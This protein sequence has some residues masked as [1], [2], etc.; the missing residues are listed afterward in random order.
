MAQRGRGQVRGREWARGVGKTDLDAHTQ[1]AILHIKDNERTKRRGIRGLS[2]SKS[3][4]HN[5]NNN[6]NRRIENNSVDLIK[7][8]WKKEK[9][10]PK[11]ERKHRGL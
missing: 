6:H 4:V 10:R 5:H 3:N 2:V 11:E 9:G 7:V 8:I 1:R